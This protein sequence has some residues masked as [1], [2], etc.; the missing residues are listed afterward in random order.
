MQSW[1]A[2]HPRRAA[3]GL[4]VPATSLHPVSDILPSIRGPAQSSGGGEMLVAS[5][6]WHLGSH[7]LHPDK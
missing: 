3:F 7:H 5:I 2:L 1:L 4:W 6:K